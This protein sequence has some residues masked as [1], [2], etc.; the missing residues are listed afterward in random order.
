VDGAEPQAG[1]QCRSRLPG[2][3]CLGEAHDPRSRQ[4]PRSRYGGPSPMYGL[5]GRSVAAHARGGAP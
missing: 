3:G 5:F 1:G 2:G 4:P